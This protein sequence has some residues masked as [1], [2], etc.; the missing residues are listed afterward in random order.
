MGKLCD[1]RELRFSVTW[2]CCVTFL[3]RE[4]NGM[5]DYENL[6]HIMINASEQ[7]LTYLE[8]GNIWDAKRVLQ[9]SEQISEDIYIATAEAPPEL[10]LI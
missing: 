5:V 1:N 8:Q 9:M 2:L 7:A 3:M 6:Y 4:G 10:I